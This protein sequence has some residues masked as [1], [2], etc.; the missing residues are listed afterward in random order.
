MILT[1]QRSYLL[2]DN[3]LAAAVAL[4]LPQK[5]NISHVLYDMPAET[6]QLTKEL[7]AQEA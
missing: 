7:A 5:N 2:F 3:I 4:L 6:S 1:R